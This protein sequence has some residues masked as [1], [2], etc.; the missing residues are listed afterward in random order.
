MRELEEE[1]F[2]EGGGE[3]LYKKAKDLI[4]RRYLFGD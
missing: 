2:F 3:G 4:M 1:F